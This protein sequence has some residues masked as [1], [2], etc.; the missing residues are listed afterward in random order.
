MIEWYSQ[1]FISNEQMEIVTL[2]K[3][4]SNILKRIWHFPRYISYFHQHL[5]V[6]RLVSIFYTSIINRGQWGIKRHSYPSIIWMNY[7]V[8]L[9][10]II[11]HSVWFLALSFVLY[12][13]HFN[14][15][16][17]NTTSY[18]ILSSHLVEFQDFWALC[19]IW[20]GAKHAYAVGQMCR[21]C[22]VEQTTDPAVQI[23][24][25]MLVCN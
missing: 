23:S 17:F 2:R 21:M 15:S 13:V 9:W 11:V 4:V 14:H 5:Y 16:Q 7:K 1:E 19:L 22:V 6:Y 25:L 20:H 3:N 8:E 12:L 18:K 10:P 24:K